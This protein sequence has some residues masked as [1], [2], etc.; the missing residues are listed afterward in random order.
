MATIVNYGGINEYDKTSRM[1]YTAGRKCLKV[2]DFDNGIVVCEPILGDEI[3]SYY[4][5]IAGCFEKSSNFKEELLKG[6]GKAE[7]ELFHTIKFKFN[8]V[9][10]FV[11]SPNFDEET[12]LKQYHDGLERISEE[13]RKE[14]EEYMKTPEYKAKRAKELRALM[15]KERVQ[16][17]VVQVANRT[18]FKLKDKAAERLWRK[19]VRINSTDGY[20]RAVVEYAKCWAKYM[21]HL[22]KKH[23]KTVFEVAGNA[24]HLCD[25][26]GIT[27]Y[28]YGCAVNMLS[29]CWKYGDDL[30]R[31][32]NKKYG[33][34]DE[35]G[36][37]NPAIITISAE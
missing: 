7:N 3:T 31:W 20:S 15:R 6:Y 19:I 1:F 22:M 34:D 16:K 14:H 28:M 29:Q 36:V 25:L 9:R 27:G 21:Q 11:Y 33:C 30:R 23:N 37:I 17:E 24:S 5:M 2:L 32:H 12:I 10:Y 13:Y 26:E 8:G 18:Y 4:E 35:D